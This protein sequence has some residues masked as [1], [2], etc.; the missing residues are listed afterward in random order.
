[1]SEAPAAPMTTVEAVIRRRMGFLEHEA[2]HQAIDQVRRTW[3][4][5]LE[6]YVEEKGDRLG[7]DRRRRL[8]REIGR[9]RKCL[10]MPPLGPSAQAIDRRRRKTRERV[11][12]YR[13]RTAPQ[14]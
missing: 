11:R 10:K 5:I 2:A 12:R 1:M 6:A 3:L 8:D 13:Q 7:P 4:P 14:I 9:L